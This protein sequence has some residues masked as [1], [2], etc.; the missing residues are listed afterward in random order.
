MVPDEAAPIWPDKS[1]TL[2]PGVLY[3]I[4]F[5]EPPLPTPSLPGQ[6][7]SFPQPSSDEL[8]IKLQP[9]Y[10]QVDLS[11]F[12]EIGW[13][14][15]AVDERHVTAREWT[16]RTARLHFQSG[17]RFSLI[18]PALSRWYPR[19]LVQKPFWEELKQTGLL[20]LSAFAVEVASNEAE[21]PKPPE[22]WLVQPRGHQVGRRWI[23][24]GKPNHCPGGEDHGPVACPGCGQ[25]ILNC[26]TCG[27]DTSAIPSYHQG[28]GDDR[29]VLCAL[30]DR[31]TWVLDGSHWDGSD[32]CQSMYAAIGTH[33]LVDYLL[34]K[35]AAPFIATP[36]LVWTDGMSKQ[37]LAW[38]ERA[39][40]PL[41]G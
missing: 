18:T 28:E 2:V 22:L 16:P 21:I 27:R 7:L 23:V 3:G 20:G 4:H 31:E 13:F 39:K 12:P 19:M 14:Q 9:G 37:Q 8:S 35:H 6:I 30:K 38:L 1:G 32:F 5:C 29:L 10:C 17:T 24:R 15:C 34:R 40:K 11:G 33:R 26:L 41:P 25:I 36:A